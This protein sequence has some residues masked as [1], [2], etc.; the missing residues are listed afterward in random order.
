M[1]RY[2]MTLVLLL[3]LMF[4]AV[5]AWAAGEQTINLKEGPDGKGAKGSAVIKD[6]E[7][8]ARGAE[9]KEITI[10]ASGLQP[11]SVYTVW[12]VNEKP[13]MDM[14]GVGTGDFSFKSDSQGRGSYTA[15]VPASELQK[16]SLLE[17]ALHPD[18]NPKN[19]DNIKIAL[20][21]DLKQPG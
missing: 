14:A 1:K 20:K 21:A 17:V 2:P 15:S 4:I 11:D 3:S 8:T 6:V 16:W 10:S 9:Q 18:G 13:K 7:G 5:V 19:M 12:F